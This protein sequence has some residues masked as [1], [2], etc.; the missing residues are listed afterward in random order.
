ME[1]SFD[2]DYLSVKDF[3]ATVERFTFPGVT[4]DGQCFLKVCIRQRTPVFLCVQLNDYTGTSITNAAESILQRAIEMLVEKG[5][6]VSKRKMSFSEYLFSE[7]FE[8]KKQEDLIRFFSKKSVW[9]EHYPPNTGL[10][11][12][13]SYAIVKFDSQLNPSWSYVR[14]ETAIHASG[15]DPSFFDVP[16]ENLRYEQN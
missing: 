6:V 7:R 15:L 5:V 1:K 13:G 4:R 10:A 12:G 14:K 9:I 11:P 2:D 3:E 16:Y 8:R